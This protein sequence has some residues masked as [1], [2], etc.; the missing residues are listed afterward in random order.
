MK[1]KWSLLNVFSTFITTPTSQLHGKR[2]FFLSTFY[3]KT[4]KIT[5]FSHT[6]HTCKNLVILL[7]FAW[8]VLR[9]KIP[10]SWITDVEVVIDVQNTF[11]RLHLPFKYLFNRH[12]VFF[13]WNRYQKYFIRHS[14]HTNSTQIKLKS[15]K[16]S[17]IHVLSHFLGTHNIESPNFK[18][19]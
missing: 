1:G 6:C 9:T 2:A 4:S 11:R 17:K 5:R 14:I 3:A 19:R 18:C 12:V 16:H 7:V 10:M 13:W 15:M 8:K